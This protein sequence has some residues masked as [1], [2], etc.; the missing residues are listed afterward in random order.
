MA[1]L[2]KVEVTAF[3]SSYEF[4]DAFKRRIICWVLELNECVPMVHYRDEWERITPSSETLE[5]CCNDK[6]AF[7]SYMSKRL[8]AMK[9]AP[10][11]VMIEFSVLP[12]Y[13]GGVISLVIRKKIKPESIYVA[14]VEHQLRMLGWNFAIAEAE[15]ALGKTLSDM[16]NAASEQPAWAKKRGVTTDRLK[17]YMTW[18]GVVACA[19]PQYEALRAAYVSGGNPAKAFAD[20]GAALAGHLRRSRE[21]TKM[22][23]PLSV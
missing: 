13:E 12:E 22:E 2:T 11:V 18:N 5:L 15:L 10:P 1:Y 4:V 23:L 3:N 7:L 17:H 9:E 19:Y 6:K 20:F 14:T 8:A 16:I 21:L